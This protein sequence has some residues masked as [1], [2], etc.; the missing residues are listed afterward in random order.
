[1]ATPFK[2]HGV[3]IF[4][5]AAVVVTV[6]LITWPY[7]FN[8]QG[9]S[10][11]IKSALSK[12]SLIHEVG[13]EVEVPIGGI[14]D[15]SNPVAPKAV[16]LEDVLGQAS[17]PGNKT[18]IITTLNE[19]WA[20]NNS[21]IDLF[22]ES[23]RSGEGTQSLLR[24]V[25]I[26]CV[27]QKAYDRCVALHPHCFQMKTAGVDFAAEKAFMSQDFLKMMWRRIE[28][29]GEVLQLGYSFIFS[30]GD[31]MWFRN[32]WVV[33]SETMDFQ[34]STDRFRHSPFDLHS[35]WPNSGFLY[36]RSNNRT[37]AM[38]RHWYEEGQRSPGK[39]DQNVLTT[40]FRHR[41]DLIRE[42]GL[43]VQFFDTVY[44]SGFCQVSRDMSKVVT[45]HSNCCIGLSSKLNDL[46][47]ALED[48][49]SY[50]DAGNNS[51]HSR[52]R[53]KLWRVPSQCDFL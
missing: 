48:W 17:M 1:M 42:L 7:F 19:A 9:S 36:A 8:H 21:M 39:N 35:N 27:D 23:F 40:L 12:L 28:F 38:Y 20:A 14:Q 41:Q 4:Y 2:R 18:V 26:V 30:D 11:Q 25:V 37:I 13:E 52:R 49:R 44:F 43:K 53:Q 51:T 24:H 15:S 45:M 22:L 33:F 32:P 50:R 31:V 29:L 5:F 10:E 6:F 34:I 46:R 3:S 47:L 16:T